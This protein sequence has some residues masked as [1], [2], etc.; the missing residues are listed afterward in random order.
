MKTI[1]R[2]D[3]LKAGLL[4]P[5]VA[6]NA[7]GIGPT[8][9]ATGAVSEVSGPLSEPASVASPTL[10][11]GRERLLLDFGW[12]FHFGHA[13]DPAKDLGYGSASAGNFRKTGN[14]MPAAS[15]SLDDADWRS[16][17]LPH[18][19]AVELPFKNDP[20]LQSKGF[21]PLGRQYPETSVGWYR[22][23]F[24]LPAG[25]AGRRITVEF[26]GAYRET[27]VV[28]N[29]FYI[30]RHSGGYD[31]FSFDVIGLHQPWRSATCC[32]CAS[33]PRRATAGSMKVPGSIGT[34]GW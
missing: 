24:E 28:F 18:D 19:W 26:D 6:A 25:D 29:G 33:M 3:V 32:W 14:F 34:C 2:R 10:G 1:S 11:A 13:N 8:H 7:R 9:S 4:A 15:T 20:D 30:G 5:A 21:Y 12:R 23:V 31:P 17:D 27:L 16:I 22:R